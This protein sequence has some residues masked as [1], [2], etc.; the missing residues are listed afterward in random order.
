MAPQVTLT[1]VDVADVTIIMD[2]G[3]D[4][5]AA[6]T[7]RAQ[8]PPVVWDAFQRE[9]LRAEHGLS[10]LLTIA[11]GGPRDTILYDCGLSRDRVTHNLDVLGL[12]IEHVPTGVL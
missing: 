6:S 11:R 7:P 3:L 9:P 5:L 4:A 1:P 12:R 8:R 2:N 10:L